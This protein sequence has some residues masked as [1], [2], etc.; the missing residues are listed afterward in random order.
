MSDQLAVYQVAVQV[1][2]G[3]NVTVVPET[4]TFDKKNSKRQFTVSIAADFA[5]IGT[6]TPNNKYTGGYGYLS[7][8]EID[9]K[10]VVRSPIM[11]AYAP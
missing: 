7:W 4:L 2:K 8:I 5:G 11:A 10:H 6:S 3:V 9:G 1:S